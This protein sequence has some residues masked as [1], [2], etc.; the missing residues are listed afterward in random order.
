M[1][2]CVSR[3]SHS[4]PIGLAETLR[5]P[6][7]VASEIVD[8]RSVYGLTVIEVRFATSSMVVFWLT[9]EPW[10]P[11]A[12]RGYPVERV[13]IS[14]WRSGR[15]I[16]VPM[17]WRGRS[18]QHRYPYQAGTTWGLGDLCLWFPD[19]PRPLRWEWGDGLVEYITIVHRHLMAEEYARRNNGAWPAEDAPH[20][21]GPHPIRTIELH[22]A[23]A[24]EGSK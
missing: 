7:R 8:A 20:G 4:R 12:E 19:D 2:G 6:H 17:D 13:A 9:L 10:A 22:N 24:G 3:V 11:M 23:A 14:V 1:A 18:W 16:A 15:I 21:T 5:C